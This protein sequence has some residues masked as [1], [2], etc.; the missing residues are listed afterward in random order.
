MFDQVP[1]LPVVVPA[2]AAALAVLLTVL[3]RRGRLTAPR[4]AVAVALCV[5][6]AGIVANTVFPIFLDKPAADV[7]WHAHLALAPL[8]GYEAAD[9]LKNVAVFVPLGVLTALLGARASGRR[10][11]LVAVSVSLGIEVSQLV[12]A[13]LLGGGH[14]ADVN[15][16]LF[17]VLGGALGYGLLR[18]GTRVPRV[19]AVVDRF[20]WTGPAPDGARAA[21][22][23][24]VGAAYRG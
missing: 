1:V 13:H 16:L 4:A 7:P 11:V 12:A 6:G 19:A 14:L 18:A 23:A 20:R 24:V 3:L 10:A 22:P 2:A 5:Y 9:A 17:N 21:G 15:D 8:V